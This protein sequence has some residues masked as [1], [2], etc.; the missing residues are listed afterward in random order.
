MRTLSDTT[1]K[2]LTV[3]LPNSKLLAELFGDIRFIDTSFGLIVYGHKVLAQVV[4]DGESHS[5][6]LSATIAPAHTFEDWLAL[7]NHTRKLDWA[8]GKQ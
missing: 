8:G 5:R 1:I 3:T 2:R 4:I 6:L 7:F